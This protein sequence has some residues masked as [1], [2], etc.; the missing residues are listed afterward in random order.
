MKPHTGSTFAD[1]FKMAGIIDQNHVTKYF[2]YYA[3]LE[4]LYPNACLFFIK[5]IKG[6]CLV[7]I[8]DPL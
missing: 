1:K 6:Y 5:V 4:L 2:L 7:A 8:M 3:V